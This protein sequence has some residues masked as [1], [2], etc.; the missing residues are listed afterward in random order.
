[1]RTPSRFDPIGNVIM[2]IWFFG[3]LAAVLAELYL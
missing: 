1:M 2:A 3:I